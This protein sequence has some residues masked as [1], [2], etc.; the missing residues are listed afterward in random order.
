M[1]VQ[2]EQQSFDSDYVL[3]LKQGDPDTQRHFVNYFGDLLRV[4]LRGKLRAPQLVEEAKQETFL[5]VLLTLRERGIDHPERLGAFVNSV[6]N[7]VVMEVYRAESRTAPMPE[8]YHPADG[9][10]DAESEM[11][12]EQKRN[13][14]RQLLEELPPKECE[15]LRQVFLEEKDKD[16]IC[17]Q[18]GVDRNYLRVLLH[19]ARNRFSALL[20]ERGK[21]HGVG[22]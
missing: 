11:V 7:N 18:F 13:L 3:R 5:R 14:V 4:K 20:G 21:A 22:E 17:Q 12:N 2:L 1:R 10:I 19:R 9:Q 8:N 16:D 15:L 6:C